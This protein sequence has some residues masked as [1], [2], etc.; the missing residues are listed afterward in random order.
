MNANI[1]FFFRNADLADL[2]NKN[3]MQQDTKGASFKEE[4]KNK[5][6]FD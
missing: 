2:Q 3:K 5:K 4:Y 6:Y 1:L